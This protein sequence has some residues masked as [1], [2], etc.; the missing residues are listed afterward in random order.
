MME[1]WKDYK[2]YGKNIIIF[3]NL[4]DMIT[5]FHYNI[6][7][8]VRDGYIKVNVINSSNIRIYTIEAKFNVVLYTRIWEAHHPR[9]TITIFQICGLEQGLDLIKGIICSI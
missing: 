5:W 4:G 6:L 8:R 1:A 3:Y 7:L 9:M 2:H